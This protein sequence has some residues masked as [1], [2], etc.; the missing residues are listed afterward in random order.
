MFHFWFLL[1]IIFIFL[2]VSLTV[3]YHLFRNFLQQKYQTAQQEYSKG[4]RPGCLPG[5]TAEGT[6]PQGNFC[7]DALGDNPSCCAYDFQCEACKKGARFRAPLQD[8]KGMPSL[9]QQMDAFKDINL[10]GQNTRDLMPSGR[11]SATNS[12][13]N[14]IPQQPPGLQQVEFQRDLEEQEFAKEQQP[15]KEHRLMRKGHIIS[16]GP[17]RPNIIRR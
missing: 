3:I 13:W 16:E 12:I 17:L 11:G 7:Y 6:C 5:C 1:F 4:V 9:S 8:K 15:D 10:H 2:A 14:Q